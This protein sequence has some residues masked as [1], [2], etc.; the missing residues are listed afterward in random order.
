MNVKDRFTNPK[1]RAAILIRTRNL[2]MSRS[3]HGYVRGNTVKFYEWLEAQKSGSLPEGPP[4]W[5]CGDCHVG[6]LGPVANSAGRIEIQIRDL[7]QTVIGNPAHDLVRLGLSLAS[8]ARGSD[9][10]GVIT[11]K[12]VEQM[13]VGYEKSFEPD[14]N[15]E[16]DIQEPKAIRLVSKLAAAASWETLAK[17]RIEDIRP[18]L[19]LGPRFWPITKSET[20]AIERLFETEELRE[21]AT[22]L[23]SRKVNARVK[24]LDAA[25][26]MKGCS[27]LG[28]LRYAVILRVGGDKGRNSDFCMMDIKEAAPAV[29]PRS[30]G[31]KMPADPAERV[32]EGARHLSPHLGKRMR[33][34][35]LMDKPVF[36]RELL[37]QD[38]KIEIEQLRPEEAMRV[39]HFLAAVVGKAHSRQMDAETRKKWL[40][41]LQRNR[42]T[43]LDAPT[44]LWVSTVDL[45][46]DHER[47]YLE[48]CR[49]HALQMD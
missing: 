12:M 17:E 31:V 33:S 6:N 39:A 49:K 11:A 44:W 4:T 7:D 29:A 37:P 1:A 23:R 10:P 38:L 21:L 36:V 13:M 24:L 40:K 42:S 5:I 18:T 26:W 47:A 32:V 48:H 43:S 15:D 35:R 22:M 30:S 14:F 25:Y 45:L 27:S 41:D 9:L 16:N 34:L 2:K 20:R 8:A 28:R 19:P 3:S 46:A